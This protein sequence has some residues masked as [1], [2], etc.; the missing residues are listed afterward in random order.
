MVTI[1]ADCF[2]ETSLAWGIRVVPLGEEKVH[3]IWLPKSQCE[4]EAQSRWSV[5]LW[6]AEKHRMV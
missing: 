1:D 4:R 5:P 3:E 2:A 6:L